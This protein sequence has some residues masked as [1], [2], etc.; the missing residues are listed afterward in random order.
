MGEGVL[1]VHIILVEGLGTSKLRH[2]LEMVDSVSPHAISAWYY[3]VQSAII[4][5]LTAMDFAGTKLLT[6]L[7]RLYYYVTIN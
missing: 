3:P 6:I 2:V 7:A 4:F 1:V 5:V